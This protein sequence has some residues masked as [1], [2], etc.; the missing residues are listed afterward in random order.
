ME[1]RSFKPCVAHPKHEIGVTPRTNC[2]DCWSYYFRYRP[3]NLMAM[4]RMLKQLGREKVITI[5]GDKL[6][7]QLERFQRKHGLTDKN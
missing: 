7:K 3:G 5:A 2:E 1:S 4:E 6:I